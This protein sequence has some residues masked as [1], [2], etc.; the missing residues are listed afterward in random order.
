MKLFDLLNKLWTV[1]LILDFMEVLLF[2][3]FVY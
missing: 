2:I 1:L 3:R